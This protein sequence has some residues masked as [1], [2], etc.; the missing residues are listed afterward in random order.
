M[1]RLTVKELEKR[2]QAEH[3]R[4]CYL[5]VENDFKPKAEQKTTQEIAE[6]LGVSR[7]TLYKWRNRDDVIKLQGL[8]SERQ[9]DTYRSKVDRALL[10]LI[11]DGSDRLPSVKAIELYYKLKGLMIDRSVV[12]STEED[13]SPRITQAELDAELEELNKML[14]D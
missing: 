11:D 12:G 1:P 5:L 2:M 13:V 6:E 10:R 7:T 3:V 8:L 9:M 4:A 14:E